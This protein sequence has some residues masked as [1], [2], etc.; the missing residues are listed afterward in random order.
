LTPADTLRCK[1]LLMLLRKISQ[2]VE[3]HS[4]HLNKNIG[5]T[6]PQL[7]LLHELSF[8]ENT[9][10]ELAKKVSLSQGTVTDIIHRL[11]KK[12][13]VIKRRGVSDKRSVLVRLSDNCKNILDL[14]PSSLQET[15]T[16]SFLKLDEWEQLMIL[17][18]VHRIAKMM[19]S[20][21]AANRRHPD[22]V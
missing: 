14:A 1:E 6:G 19:S 16:T 5:L 4:K 7:V 21:K 8:G 9:V 11:E 22:P 3:Q 17:S 13:L 15:F 2:S 20:E 12:S 18:A 10:T